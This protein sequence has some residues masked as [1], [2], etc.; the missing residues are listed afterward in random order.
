MILW[1]YTPQI[2]LKT[3]NKAWW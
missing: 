2:Q 1:S 3:W